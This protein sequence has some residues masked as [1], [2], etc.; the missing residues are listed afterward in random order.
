[1]WQLL[2]ETINEWRNDNASQ[3][4]AALAYY[5]AVSVAPLLVLI[6][7]L[8]GSILGTQRAQE[9]LMAQ[10][11]GSVGP[12]G[13]RFLAIVLE[14]AARP[15]LA[16]VTGIFS[17]LVLLWGSTNLFSQ[18][19]SSLNAIWNVEPNPNRGILSTL[20][21]R[22][23]SFLLVIGVALLL[24][25]ALILSAVLSALSN[26]GPDWLPGVDWLWQL[27]NVALSLGVLTVLFAAIF[28]VLPDAHI[29]WRD[30]WLGGA[31]TA[32]LFTVGNFL[33]SFYLGNAGSVYGAVGSV[34]VFLLWVYY[35]AQ[36]L[37][38]GAEFTQ[39]YARRTRTGQA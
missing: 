22:L 37:F 7:V 30:V 29:A 32:A 21:D 24:L 10:L 8:V 11:E 13:S 20:K 5:T 31:V 6:V 17:A 18:L 2:K 28:K 15:T 34:M 3:L 14:N 16:T 4:A 23:L 12:D 33:L 36:I 27:L 39:V 1:M 35:S 25:A 26:A 9:E 19:Q 38:L